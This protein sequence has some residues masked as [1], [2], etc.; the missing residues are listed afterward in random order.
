MA[1]QYEELIDDDG[2][3]AGE[4]TFEKA[5]EVKPDAPGIV[6]VKSLNDNATLLGDALTVGFESISGK[7]VTQTQHNKALQWLTMR[8]YHKNPFTPAAEALYELLKTRRNLDTVVRQ[9]AN[10]KAA[11]SI[12][13]ATP[14]NARAWQG[15]RRPISKIADPAEQLAGSTYGQSIGLQV[16]AAVEMMESALNN[17]GKRADSVQR[18]SEYLANIPLDIRLS[19][20]VTCDV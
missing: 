4:E 9:L 18:I 16:Q 12:V 17:E 2:I 11:W 8:R 10:L 6:S 14:A 15:L 20:Y 3:P 19:D 1:D 13:E 5:E 7:M